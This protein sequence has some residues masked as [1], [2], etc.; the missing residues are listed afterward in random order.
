MSAIHLWTLVR[1]GTK[2]VNI[3]SCVLESD[4]SH[5]KNQPLIEVNLF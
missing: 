4:I 1:A 3:L 5:W 2:D